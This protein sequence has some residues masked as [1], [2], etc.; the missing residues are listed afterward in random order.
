MRWTSMA[1]PL[2]WFDYVR[3]GMGECWLCPWFATIKDDTELVEAFLAHWER[4][5]T[6]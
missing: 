5:H 6:G 2:E 1:D 4:T 3:P